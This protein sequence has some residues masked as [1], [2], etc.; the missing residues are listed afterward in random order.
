MH[1]YV[2]RMEAELKELEERISKLSKFI[3]SDT[4][5]YI[6][7]ETQDL[8]TEQ[9][10]VMLHYQRL[11]QKRLQLEYEEFNAIEELKCK[12]NLLAH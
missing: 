9:I 6:R 10:D 7:Y 2:K 11:L 5:K 8:L 12:S 4:F 3:E 1:D